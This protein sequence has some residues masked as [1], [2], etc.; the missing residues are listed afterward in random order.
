MK[1]LRVFGS[2][3]NECVFRSE[4]HGRLNSPIFQL[5]VERFVCFTMY[6]LIE[7]LPGLS[8]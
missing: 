6:K 2:C 1:L 8:L 3:H 5:K 4:L 7:A